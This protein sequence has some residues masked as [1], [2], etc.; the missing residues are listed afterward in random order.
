MWIAFA[1]FALLLVYQFGKFMISFWEKNSFTRF[2]IIIIGAGITGLSTACSVKENHP[3]KSVLVLERGVFPS[4]ASTKNAGFACFA[5]ACEMMADAKLCD[6]ETVAGLALQ[7]YNGLEKLRKRLGDE[8]IGYTQNGGYELIFEDDEDF[9]KDRI[10]GLN[11]LLMPHFGT[12]V[13][14][15]KDELA[16]KFGF[17]GV[18]HLIYTPLEGQIDTGLMMGNLA[19]Y[20][21]ALG[22]KIIYGADVI[23]FDENDE[24]VAVFVNHRV[25]KE[26]IQF[27]CN[28]LALCTNAFTSQFLPELNIKPGRGQVLITKPIEGLK[29]KGTFHFEEGFYYFRDYGDR[30]LLGGGRNLDFDTETSTEFE[31]N[32]YIYLELNDLLGEVILPGVHFEID[33]RWQGIMGF[34]PD[35]KPI[36]KKIT[37]NIAVGFGCNG[38]GVALGSNTG[39]QLAKLVT[40]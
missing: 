11:Q 19:A 7:R 9:E 1:C 37:E 38:M 30:V 12:Q 29:F 22:V 8:K 24:T 25:L 31:A 34:S 2:D 10:D 26:S 20:A 35:K 28:K 15:F 18:K 32:P 39:E 27:T 23:E 21:I 16:D 4:G 17:K 33:M 14:S 6:N 36:I 13:F 5:K 3:G 40:G